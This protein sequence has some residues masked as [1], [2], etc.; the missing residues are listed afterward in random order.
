MLQL[1]PVQR[2]VDTEACQCRCWGPTSRGHVGTVGTIATYPQNTKRS[3]LDPKNYGGPANGGLPLSSSLLPTTRELTAMALRSL[4]RAGVEVGGRVAGKRATHAARHV[5]LGAERKMSSFV[6]EGHGQGQFGR[7]QAPS[8]RQ[9]APYKALPC[10][11]FERS[12]SIYLFFRSCVGSQL[13]LIK[14][15]YR[16]AVQ[17]NQMVCLSLRDGTLHTF[18]G[19]RYERGLLSGS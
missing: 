2:H 12:T 3:N 17:N 6:G 14:S 7:S 15:M 4:S 8:Y 13:R 18:L 11:K 9:G 10:R 19:A 5:V 16:D 1:H